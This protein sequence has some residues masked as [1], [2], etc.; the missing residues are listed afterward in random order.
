MESY[1]IFQMAKNKLMKRLDLGKF[2]RE[3]KMTNLAMRGLLSQSQHLFCQR[4]GQILVREGLL[5]DDSDVDSN[6]SVDM[7]DYNSRKV[8]NDAPKQE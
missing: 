7:D 4:Q 2:L 3:Q 6:D 5:R 1:R 8:A